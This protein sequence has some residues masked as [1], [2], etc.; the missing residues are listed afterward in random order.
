MFIKKKFNRLL[1][2]FVDWLA[3]QLDGV[4]EWFAN[5]FKR[6]KRVARTCSGD[7]FSVFLAIAKV[8]GMM[9][10]F[11][12]NEHLD[13]GKLSWTLYGVVDKEGDPSPLTESF[14]RA[15]VRQANR[16]RKQWENKYGPNRF[17]YEVVDKP[18]TI[19]WIKNQV[20]I[21]ENHVAAFNSA[22]D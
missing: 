7:P 1:D 16:M 9:G 2:G 15:F 21:W 5:H 4:E 18:V 3:D 13:F 12:I 20:R 22:Y 14:K 6:T 17:S 19:E 8:H 11:D 10:K